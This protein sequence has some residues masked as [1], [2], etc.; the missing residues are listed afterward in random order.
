MTTVPTAP[1]GWWHDYVCP[2][3]H[4]ELSGSA[5]GG[6]GCPRG[7]VVAGEKY[8]AAL[9]TLDHQRCAREVR[10]LARTGDA[11]D[12]RRAVAVLGEIAKVYGDVVGPGWNDAAESWML[13]GRMFAQALTEAQW[14]VQVADAVLV[15]GPE[16]HVAGVDDLLEGL[17]ATFEQAYGVLVDERQDERNNYTAW[18]CAAGALVSRALDAPHEV[19]ATW[20]TRALAHLEIAVGDDGWEWEG[21]TYY[22]VF[23][24]RAYLLTFRDAVPADLPRPAVERLAAMVR[25]LAEV[26]APDGTLPAIHDG[27]YDRVPMHHEVLEIAAM[28]RGLLAPAGLEAV[29]TA[30]RARL[31]RADDGLDRL[32][33]GW[34]C[35]P[36]VQVPAPTRGSV[37]FPQVGYAVLR[38]DADTWQAVVDAGPHGGSHGHHDKLALYLYGTAPWQPAPGVPPYAS[39]LRRGHYAR[40]LAHPTLRVDGRDQDET[41]GRVERWAPEVGLVVTSAEPH[42]GVR[43][44][45]ATRLTDGVLTDVV[46]VEADEPHELV[47]ALRP[48]VDLTVRHVPDGAR[49]TWTADDGASLHGTHVASPGAALAV[50]PG[51]GPSDDP[52]AVRPVADWTATG[53]RAVF[54]SLFQQGPDPAP[55][56]IDLAPDGATFHLTTPDGEKTIEGAP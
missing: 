37:Y 3:H 10:R 46:T 12:R 45:R 2:T 1:G 7:C 5:P 41:T 30:A 55:A 42:P 14:A 56:R 53:D 13:R 52:A 43:V 28:A 11:A 44:R 32:L 33:D 9:R 24:L 48:A 39:A 34:F 49:T 23:V 51:R 31:G 36:P 8:D 47:L 20:H 26:A 15:L 19:V 35:G 6:H 29:A 18:L 54:A 38:D 21:S 40:T 4:V 17:L 16:A 27:P 50:V 22:H 25:V